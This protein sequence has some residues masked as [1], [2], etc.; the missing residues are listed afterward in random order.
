MKTKLRSPINV[1]IRRRAGQSAA[2]KRDALLETAAERA[3]FPVATILIVIVMELVRRVGGG[4]T[5]LTMFFVLLGLSIAYAAWQL[6]RTRREVRMWTLGEQGER[7]VGQILDRE[8]PAHGYRVYHDLQVR[9][10]GRMMN[11]DHLLVGPNGVFLIEDKTWSKPE[12]GQSVIKC[13][14]K[15]V[16]RNDVAYRKP[17]VEAFALAKEANAYL[18]SLTGRSY[19]VKPV[20]VFVGWY[21]QAENRHD[22]PLLVLSEKVLASFLPRHRPQT[23]PS[24]GDI[25]LLVAKLDAAV[26]T[27]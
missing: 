25:R 16:F 27:S 17:V 12:R 9:K 5:P 22:S 4:Q 7:Y 2:E 1:P 10:K 15:V 19:P 13:D 3:V 23:I 6:V 11:I 20:L 24:E 21:N 8:M 14:G 26:E 18:H